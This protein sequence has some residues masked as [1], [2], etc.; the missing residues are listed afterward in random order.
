MALVST[1][2]AADDSLRLGVDWGKLGAVLRDGPASLLL[3][4]EPERPDPP[5]FGTAPQMSVVARDWGASQSLFGPLGPTDQLRL[6]RSLRMVVARVRLGNGRITPFAQVGFGQWRVDT[7]VVQMPNDV[8]LA[9]QVGGG[10]E[11]HLAPRAVV[12]LE[13]GCTMLYRD[14]GERYTIPIASPNLWGA[15]LAARAHF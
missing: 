12:A 8:E 13:G 2:A 10:L 4:K 3:P 9:G 14:A 11:L 1:A 6:S 5:L 7:S 15:L